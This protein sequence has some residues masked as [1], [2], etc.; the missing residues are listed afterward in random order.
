MGLGVVA[1]WVSKE[2]RYKI[3]EVLVSTRS[4]RNLAAQ[5]GVS[6]TV[7]NKYLKRK[8]HPSD[9]TL[10]RVLDAVEE[11]E[12][13]RIVQILID[14]IILAL[15]KL[16]RELKNNGD[17]DALDYLADKLVGVLEMVRDDRG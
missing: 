4:A 8:T 16:V 1:K 5:L 9:E 2:A 10:A 12:R 6:H 14:D 7:V 15:K 17:R 11:Y 3:I 13:R